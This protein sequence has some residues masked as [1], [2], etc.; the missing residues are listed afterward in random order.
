MVI[1]LKQTLEKSRYDKPAVKVEGD[2]SEAE[3]DAI[4]GGQTWGHAR[5]LTNHNEIVVKIQE[6]VMSK[7][8]QKRFTASTTPEKT[9]QHKP[10]V[11]V[12]EELTEG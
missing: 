2:L 10:F 6:G 7:Q 9:R 8:Q 4:A 1:V 3:L 12:E 5:G 11:Q